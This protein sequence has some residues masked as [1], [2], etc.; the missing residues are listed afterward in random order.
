MW[1][2]DLNNWQKKRLYITVAIYLVVG[3]T[4]LSYFCFVLISERNHVNDTFEGNLKDEPQQ[5][6]LAR[7]QSKNA[8]RVT[9]GTYV[10]NLREINMKSS[11]FRVEMHVWFS[12]EGDENLD[13]ANNFRVYKGLINKKAI[14]KDI[15]ENGKNY[16]LVAVDVSVSKN[17]DTKCFPLES[18]QISFYIEALQ[19]IQEVLL[20]A[21]RVN[22]GLNR[23]IEI[24]GFDF[25]RYGIGN[26]SYIYDT[27][28]GD[29]EVPE[30][31]MTSEVI[32]TLEVNR[33]DFGLYFKCF[34]A[35]V[36]TLTWT[37]IALFICTYH[38]VDPLGMLPGALFGTVGNIM[39]GAS[40]L[41]DALETGLL[42]FVNLWGIFTILGVAVAI[43]NIN[44]I[45]NTYEDKEFATLYGRVLF[46]IMLVFAVGGQFLLPFVTYMVV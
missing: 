8:I 2:N 36:G 18:H 44:R 14:I 26:V 41:P 17:F 22:S 13:M 9:T 12:W 34:I 10:E 5:A 21:D 23:Y 7:E 43:I 20:Q 39:V 27:T 38:R 40:L 31:T 4:L 19:P 3:L 46:Y 6:E 16:Q 30:N 37:L 45:R 28:F 24:G 1:I 33:S 42:E 25:M 35:L 11:Y 15:H 32:T 29:P